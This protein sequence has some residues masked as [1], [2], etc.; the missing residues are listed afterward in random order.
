M[1]SLV[2][3]SWGTA[4]C[5]PIFST[6]QRENRYPVT[7][8]PPHQQP[9]ALE[10]VGPERGVQRVSPLRSRTSDAFSTSPNET[11]AHVISFTV[12]QAPV[13]ARRVATR[14]PLL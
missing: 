6:P 4:P 3:A 14:T 5:L 9:Q 8:L 10:F 2:Y 13:S 1:C 11:L 12:F 7:L